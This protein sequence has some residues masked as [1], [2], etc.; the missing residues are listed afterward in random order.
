VSPTRYGGRASGAR[1]LCVS[2][3]RPKL[4]VV[5]AVAGEAD[6]SGGSCGRC[7]VAAMT[8]SAE[9]HMGTAAG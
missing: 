1:L 6:G 7:G 5:T 2:G 3:R 8:A 9:G 4:G